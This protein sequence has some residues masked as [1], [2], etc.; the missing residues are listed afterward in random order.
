M[1]ENKQQDS[2]IGLMTDSHPDLLVGLLGILKSGSAYVP[3]N[4][5]LPLE[6][7][8]FVLTDCGIEI[9]V[10]ESKYLETARRLSEINPSLRHVVCLD[11]AEEKGGGEVSV[12]DRSD[13]SGR[14]PL[15]GVAVD[16]D[17]LAYVI[18]TSGSTGTPKGVAVS[19]RNLLPLFSWA[20]PFFPLRPSTR[21]LQTLS[22]CFDF[23]AFE[24]FSTLLCG[25][26]LHFLPSGRSGDP[27]AAAAYVRERDINTLHATPS[28]CRALVAA[29][30]VSGEES[31]LRSL[32]VVHLGGEALEWGLVRRVR[33]AAGEGCRVYNGYGP[34]EASINCAIAE[35][36]RGAVV[37]EAVA[38]GGAVSEGVGQVSIGRGT[39]AS[40]LYVLGVCGELVP[41]G[42]V[43]ELYVGGEGVARGYVKRAGLTA[44]RFMPDAFSGEAG[45][46]LYR[47]GDLVRWR[48][49]GQLE[50]VGRADEQVK[51]RGYR[52]EL[53]E[54]EAAL[55]AC[56]G[57]RA[58]VVAAREEG[59]GERRLVAYV[60]AAEGQEVKAGELREALRLRL[61]EYM[62]PAQFVEME[63]LPM[64]PNGKVDRKALPA[65][66]RTR[67]GSGMEYR[68]P[69]NATEQRLC[70]L[71]AEVLKLERVGIDDNFFELGGH[72]LLT[73]R[74]ISHVREAFRVEIPIRL[75]F[76]TPTVAKLA[77]E[78]ERARSA[79]TDVSGPAIVPVSRDSRR[80]KRS[81][82]GAQP[83][84]KE[85][86]RVTQ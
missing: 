12:Y 4:P 16:P 55:S 54:V 48:A 84:P 47:T 32:E 23:G 57:V 75:V 29:A 80:V 81:S 1:T 2:L 50:Y 83:K 17:E 68:Q 40:R 6:R 11:D 72:S 18:Y 76:E 8:S 86:T 63:S 73:T 42:V 26:Q 43:G 59:D 15:S 56:E 53:G 7:I 64:T 70:E 13:Y 41:A 34:T 19:H 10:T 69:R 28:F 3:I 78:I 25:G 49:E 61:P 58:S 31:A 67:E 66:D 37:D 45:G 79:G 52:I 21:A 27:A 30:S 46:R 22:H 71:W 24:L 51:V 5:G 65:P 38:E 20:I 36:A 44:E 62:V 60:V 9:L 33:E 82:L 35:A 85:T 77:A 14:E 74:I 39:G